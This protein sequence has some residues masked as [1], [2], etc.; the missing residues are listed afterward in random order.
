MLYILF[1]LMLS[2]YI[3]VCVLHVQ[4]ISARTCHVSCAQELSVRTSLVVQVH[5]G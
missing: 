3:S 4:Y 5:S 1:F 2:L